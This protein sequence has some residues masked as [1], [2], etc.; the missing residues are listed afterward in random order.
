MQEPH[1]RKERPGPGRIAR[2]L[3]YE[4]L[5]H[6]DGDIA[7]RRGQSQEV[8]LWRMVIE[9]CEGWGVL[10]RW[11]DLGE[12]YVGVEPEL[13]RTHGGKEAAEAAKFVTPKV[14]GEK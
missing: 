14:P 12:E 8:Q 7:K 10:A 11:R 9:G 4:T 6:S 2:R 3:Y 1:G 13:P 5:H